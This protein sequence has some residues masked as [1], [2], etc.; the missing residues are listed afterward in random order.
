M[1]HH[2]GNV[3]TRLSRM[4]GCDLFRVWLLTVRLTPVK[5]AGA[6]ASSG[7]VNARFLFPQFDEHV[8]K[9]RIRQN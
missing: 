3:F 1:H 7:V 6:L 9:V 8:A 4:H 2:G 5:A